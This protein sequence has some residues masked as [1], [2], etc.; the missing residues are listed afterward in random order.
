MCPK[1]RKSSSEVSASVPHPHHPWWSSFQFSWPH[2]IT[3]D[4]K[5]MPCR[6]IVPSDILRKKWGE[7]LVFVSSLEGTSVK[8]HISNHSSVSP[9][10]GYHGTITLGG[11]LS[12]IR[13]WLSNPP[14]VP[15]LVV[16]QP[17]R[18]LKADAMHLG[19]EASFSLQTASLSFS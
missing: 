19:K 7:S 14:S 5:T 18:P 13:G 3:R 16:W 6:G 9:R 11:V 17:L 1:V 8:S 10:L 2:P 15:R 12:C 4:T